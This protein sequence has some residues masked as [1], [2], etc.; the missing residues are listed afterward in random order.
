MEFFQLIYTFSCV[1][2]DL[3]TT[4][5]FDLYNERGPKISIDIEKS[6]LIEGKVGKL[7]NIEQLKTSS[8]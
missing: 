4:Y 7:R 5:L 2:I 8:I 3:Y 6:I 1:L